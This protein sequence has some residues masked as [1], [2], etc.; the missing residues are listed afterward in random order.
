M[1]PPKEDA[2]PLTS[3]QKARKLIPYMIIVFSVKMSYFFDR[4]KGMNFQIDPILDAYK[5]LLHTDLFF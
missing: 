4:E 1:K 2:K 3:V 5:K